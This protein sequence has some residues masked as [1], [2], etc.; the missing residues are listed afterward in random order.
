MELQQDRPPAY[1]HDDSLTLPSV[2]H[3]DT[4]TSPPP[5]LNFS[6]PD[7]KS[8]GLPDSTRTTFAPPRPPHWNAPSTLSTSSF[9]SVPNTTPG[10][11]TSPKDSES[12]ASYDERRGRAPS[13]MSL[14][15]ADTRM[16]AEALRGLRN[17]EVIRS[18]STLSTSS[19]VQPNS[20]PSSIHHSHTGTVDDPEPLLSLLTASHPWLGG[21]IETSLSAYNTTKHYSPAFLRNSAEF[22]ERNIGS[23]VVGAVNCVS[24]HTGVETGIRRYLGTRRLSDGGAEHAGPKRR[25]VEPD[26]EKGAFEPLP[27]YDDNRSP[28]YV[29]TE[30]RND[31]RDWRTNLAV[32]TSGLGAAL[33]ETSLRNLKT[34]LRLLRGAAQHLAGLMHTLQELLRDYERSLAGGEGDEAVERQTQRAYA[35]TPEQ[36]AASHALAQRIR[37]LGHDV[38]RT[39]HGV[40]RAVSTHAGSAL[41]ANAGA[42]VRRQLLSI[43]QRWRIAEAGAGEGGAGVG[44]EETARW[45]RSMVGF[46]RQGLE[47]I[48]QV[49]LVVGATVESAEGW[50]ERMGRRQ[51]EDGGEKG[52]SAGAGGGEGGE[53]R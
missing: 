12:V 28:R 8:L 45:G 30:P 37:S 35:L 4:P 14:D 38:L 10:E 13:V 41:P 43:P 50:L 34:C 7:L 39:L 44:G 47:M 53:K 32:T 24:R 31:Q 21:T 26:V 36:Q 51:G 49:G 48:E 29:E 23:P 27:A 9:P 2:P 52:V 18:P 22:V 3:H 20:R 46:T 42:F 5:P 25:R 40:V 17:L 1:S 19:T 33:S 11:I 6:L 15:D 16:A